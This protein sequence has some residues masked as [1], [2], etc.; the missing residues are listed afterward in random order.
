MWYRNGKDTLRF[1]RGN[2]DAIK[3]NTSL[4][5]E[6][7]VGMKKEALENSTWGETKRH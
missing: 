1:K 2:I 3:N 6:P 7:F 4:Q 5:R